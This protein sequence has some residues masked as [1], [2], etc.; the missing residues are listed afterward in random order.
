VQV[1]E[2]GVYI[3]R[4]ADGQLLDLCQ[5]GTFAY[6][7][8]PRQM[9]K[10]SLMI[11]TAEQ[12]IEAGSLAVIV[13]LTQIGTQVT[14]DEWYSD[15]LS[16]VADQL[17][18]TTDA[19]AW[20]QAHSDMGITLRMT[21]FFKEV[22]LTEVSEPVAIFVDE[23]DTTLSL[24]FT[25]DFYAAVRFLYVA[26]STDAALKRL[27]FVLIGVATPSDLIRDPKRTPFNIGQRVELTDFTPD[28]AAPLGTGLGLEPGLT[29]QVMGWI[30]AWTQGHPYLTQRLCRALLEQP[31]ESWTEAAVAQGVS[32]TFFGPMSEQDNNLQFVGDMLTKRAPEDLEREV[33]DV[34]R[35]V[36]RDRVPVWDEEQS[37]VKSH[38]KLAGIV[39]RDGKQLVV[40][41]PIYREV[42]NQDW[43]KDH[44]PE[45]LWQRL[46]PAMPLVAGLTAGVLGLGAL[47]VYALDQRNE[48]RTQTDI[49]TQALERAQD[50]Q[51]EA[52]AQAAAADDARKEADDERAAAEE[53]KLDA[54]EQRDIAQQK[55]PGGGSSLSGRPS[56]PGGGGGAAAAG[57]G[58]GSRGKSAGRG[59]TGTNQ[60]GRG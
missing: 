6:V 46:K 4:Q 32:N 37:L 31:P 8:T 56:G 27:S 2:W 28:E 48:A 7:L 35:Q 39:W 42:F 41:N 25:D 58:G 50:A 57:G 19:K 23:I 38:L 18:L 59:S 11:R 21:R 44:W 15:F 55:D 40:R 47:S 34:Y 12:L 36:H 60:A 33:L 22:V 10:S 17:M 14:A 49:A 26:R 1:N 5:Q 9:G 43:I 52:E 16:L 45:T 30:L 20:W 51:L 24:D 29:Q 54:D 53:A 13:D 3:P